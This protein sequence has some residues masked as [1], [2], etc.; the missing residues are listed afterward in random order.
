MLKDFQNRRIKGKSMVNFGHWIS[1]G[2][3]FYQ[4]EQLSKL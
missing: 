3:K 2:Y 1:N 4:L